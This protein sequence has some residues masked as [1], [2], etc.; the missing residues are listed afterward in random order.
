MSTPTFLTKSITIR[1]ADGNDIRISETA[2]RC[3]VEIAIQQN[4]DRGLLATVRL[5]NAQ[6]D[7]LCNTRYSLEIASEAAAKEPE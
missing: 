7:A 6:F 3:E 4:E 2:E 5:N 1:G